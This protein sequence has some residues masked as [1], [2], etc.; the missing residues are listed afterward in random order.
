MCNAWLV[1]A[2]LKV[3]VIYIVWSLKSVYQPR[4]KIVVSYCST[5]I[6]IPFSSFNNFLF[7]LQS[8]ATLH[9]DVG[10]GGTKVSGKTV[11][12]VGSATLTSLSSINNSTNTSR[13]KNNP[14]SHEVRSNLQFAY[15]FRQIYILLKTMKKKIGFFIDISMGSSVKNS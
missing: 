4:Y 15:I 14:V 2:Q 8:P 7:C 13:N 5:L 12:G 9:K 3:R 10:G 6:S 11:G 1:N